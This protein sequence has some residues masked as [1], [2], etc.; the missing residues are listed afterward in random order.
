MTSQ[1]LRYSLRELERDGIVV[2]REFAAVPPHVEYGLTEL[3][4]T[5]CEL[6]RAIRAWAEENGPAVLAARR[7][8]DGGTGSAPPR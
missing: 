3:G 6:A 5:L 7:R 4:A 2:R 1:V 8:Y